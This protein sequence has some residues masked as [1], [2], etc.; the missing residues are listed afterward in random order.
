MST[1]EWKRTGKSYQS[2]LE[3]VGVFLFSNFPE[4]WLTAQYLPQC[5]T[6]PI[7]SRSIRRIVNFVFRLRH[8]RLPDFEMF[9]DDS[10]ASEPMGREFLSRSFCGVSVTGLCWFWKVNKLRNQNGTW[11]IVKLPPVEWTVY[12][13]HGADS[14]IREGIKSW[15]V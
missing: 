10:C 12:F 6:S 5:T 1:F 2:I 4:L 9:C 13:Y 15:V 8:R 3:T 7:S 11:E 14:F